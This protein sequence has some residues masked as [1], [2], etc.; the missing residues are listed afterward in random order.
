MDKEKFIKQFNELVDEN[1]HTSA[2]ILMAAFVGAGKYVQIL[3]A[4]FQIQ[5]L[6]SHLPE[7]LN[8]YRETVR[9]RLEPMAAA[10]L[11]EDFRRLS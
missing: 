7:T 5:G 2:Y 3:G 8:A 11:G 1:S 4:L 6:E 10:V 9:K